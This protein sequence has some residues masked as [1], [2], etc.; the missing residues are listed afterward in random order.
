MEGKKLYRWYKES[1]SGFSEEKEQLSLHENNTI[2]RKIIDKETNEPKVVRV[3]IF[4]PENIGED[5]AVDEKNINGEMHF[6][7]SNRKTK[8]IA[9]LASTLKTSIL[10][11]ILRKFGTV[12]FKV[13]SVTRDL[14]PSM[15]WLIRM[16]FMN[17][18]HIADKFHVLLHLFE[19]LQNLRTFHRQKILTVRRKKREEHKKNEL[20]RKEKCEAEKTP[21]KK[22]KIEYQEEKLEN[23]ETHCELL[24]RSQ[25]LLYKYKKDWKDS[26]EERAKILFREYPEIEKSYNL[27]CEFRD[28]YSRE[29]IG[30]SKNYLEEK[31]QIW[32]KKVEASDI[33]EMLNFKDLVER[34]LTEIL[35]HFIDG[36]TNADAESLNAKIENL[37]LSN[38][39]A[40]NI[41]FFYFRIKK[42]FS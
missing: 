5:M 7:L 36:K 8:K 35:N 39:G 13:R 18:I 20:K 16:C 24:A 17:A 38:R 34:N 2:D 22:K 41:D 31:L 42:F 3:P 23:G 25:Y 37:Y 30:K 14:A 11:E 29:N 28:W 15:K 33:E 40:R 10:E 26:Q 12:K 9:L 32:Y 1:L 27:V 6:C 19:A 4:K 21:Y